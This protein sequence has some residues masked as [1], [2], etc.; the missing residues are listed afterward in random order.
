M[1]Q[2]FRAS[3]SG[4]TSATRDLIA[5]FT[6][7]QG[8]KFDISVFDAIT[9]NAAGTNDAFHVISTNVNWDNSGA[10]QLR[11]YWT[12][13]GQNIEGDLNVDHL[14]DVSIGL[15]DAGHA[16]VLASADFSL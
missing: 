6:Q 10:G 16:V 5:D 13:T 8:D 11:A 7:S 15:V 12:G 9:T 1:F 3:D 4:V 14:A 2:V